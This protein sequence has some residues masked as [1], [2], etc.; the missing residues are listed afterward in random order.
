MSGI[1]RQ[2]AGF[3][4]ISDSQ[5]VS[6]TTRAYDE[7]RTCFSSI[8]SNDNQS[9]SAARQ[10]ILQVPGLFKHSKAILCFCIHT[11]PISSKLRT[12][13]LK[14][15]S[16]VSLVCCHFSDCLITFTSAQAYIDLSAD[17]I[18]PKVSE[19]LLHLSSCSRYWEVMKRERYQSLALR[20]D[21]HMSED[22]LKGF[23]LL[24]Q[25]NTETQIPGC[26]HGDCNPVYCCR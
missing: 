11:Y 1:A 23:D 10:D 2:Q 14:R 5:S 6:R 13:L 24:C 4:F 8:T 17:L 12:M 9:G 20:V 18:P 19:S 22:Y 3:E 15:S 21:L 25:Q 16:T 7:E 26:Q